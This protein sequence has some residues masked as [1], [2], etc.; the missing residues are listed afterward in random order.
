MEDAKLRVSALAVK[1]KGAVVFAVKIDAPVQELAYLLRSALDHLLHGDRVA[2]PVA[3]H[4]SVVD[5]LVKVIYSEICHRGHA[6]LSQGGIGFVKGGLA[7]QSHA[8][9][10]R[11]LEGK[12]HAGDARA[13]HQIVIFV[14]HCYLLLCHDRDNLVSYAAIVVVGGK[15]LGSHADGKYGHGIARMA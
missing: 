4:H 10:A 6:A 13:Y 3:G 12:A 8:S 9:G 2:E 11:H 15:T 14:C 7:H 1:V 5:V